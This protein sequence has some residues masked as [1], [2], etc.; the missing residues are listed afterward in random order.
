LLVDSI[1]QAVW[2]WD[3]REPFLGKSHLPYG[4]SALRFYGP[5]LLPPGTPLEVRLRVRRREP[6]SVI[7]DLEAVD[8]EGNVRVAMEGLAD[9][10]FPITPAL[11]RMMLEPLTQHFADVRTLDLSLPGQGPARISVG[12]VL[13]FPHPVLEGSFG[14]WRKALAFLI[15][16]PPEREEWK[17]LKVPLRREIQ[18]LLGRSAAK[19]ALRHHFQESGGRRFASADLILG[20]DLVGR[21]VLAGAWRAE[22]PEVPQVSISHTDG[23]VVAVA[24][25]LEEGVGIGVDAEKVRTP[26]QDLLDGAFSKAEL[27]LVPVPAGAAEAQR[28]EWVFRFWC[29]KEAVGKALGSGVPLDPRQFALVRA[30]AG[31]I[32]PVSRRRRDAHVEA[33]HRRCLQPRVAH[34]VGIT[35]PGDR[36]AG[37]RGFRRVALP[38]RRAG[39]PRHG[40]AP[41]RTPADDAAP[42]GRT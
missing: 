33:Q 35:D 14:V 27:A 26:S 8:S 4:M 30:D 21:P 11:H 42:A 36:P 23:L 10:E 34:V 9:R 40:R 32:D 16:S 28:S 2:L 12:T 39:L 1:G 3:S 18:W 22:L 41:R 24:A 19:D 15:L 37:T 17:G 38:G 29:A 25:G 6:L 5:R 31:R 7:A 13:D 20:N